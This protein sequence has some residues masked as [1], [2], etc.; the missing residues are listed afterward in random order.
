MNS[1]F[2]YIT[3]WFCDQNSKPLK[4][5]DKIN[6]QIKV[7]NIR[8]KRHLVQPRDRIFLKGLGFLS[9]TKI[10]GKILVKYK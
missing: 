10:M 5:E 7:E 9:F 1:K 2:L 8:M 4:I 3:V 6:L